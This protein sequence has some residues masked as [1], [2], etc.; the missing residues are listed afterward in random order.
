MLMLNIR[1]FSTN[2][3][4]FIRVKTVLF[5]RPKTYSQSND[6]LLIDQCLYY[7]YKH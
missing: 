3:T 2:I 4:R 5:I 1:Q 7:V 6:I